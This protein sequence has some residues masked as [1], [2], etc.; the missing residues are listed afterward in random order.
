MTC[1]VT[2]SLTASREKIE[3]ATSGAIAAGCVG[4][5]DFIPSLRAAV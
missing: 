2:A 1:V 4:V 3:D 5:I